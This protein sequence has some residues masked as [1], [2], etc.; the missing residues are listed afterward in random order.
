MRPENGIRRLISGVT[1][2]RCAV[3]VVTKITVASGAPADAAAATADTTRSADARS[4]DSHVMHMCSRVRLLQLP[5]TKR[6]ACADDTLPW[7]ARV[8]SPNC[9]IARSPGA[10]G[11]TARIS[12]SATAG[13]R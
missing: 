7:L 5:S 13:A 11:A 6:T 9:S 4:A 8:V 1:G 3:A 2:T 12:S 10:C